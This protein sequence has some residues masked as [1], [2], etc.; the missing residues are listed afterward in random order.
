MWWLGTLYL[1]ILGNALG[2]IGVSSGIA[3]TL[4]LLQ[5]STEVMCQMLGSMALGKQK[6]IT[7]QDVSR[8]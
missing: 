5:P 3:A 7:F 4:G 8:W 6:F 2:I 1:F